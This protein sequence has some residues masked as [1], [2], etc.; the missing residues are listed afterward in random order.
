MNSNGPRWEP[1]GT[2]DKAADHSSFYPLPLIS[3][4]DNLCFNILWCTDQKAG[5]FFNFYE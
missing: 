3:N 5:W 4:Q 1:C 2:L